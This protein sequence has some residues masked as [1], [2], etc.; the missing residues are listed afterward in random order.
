[1]PYLVSSFLPYA[2]P[3]PCSN[4]GLNIQ[5]SSITLD[6][7]CKTSKIDIILDSLSLTSAMHVYAVKREIRSPETQQDS[8]ERYTHYGNIKGAIARMHWYVIL[9]RYRFTLLIHVVHY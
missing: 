1:M 7:P 4:L 8:L 6:S 9:I 3:V 2:L 5:Y